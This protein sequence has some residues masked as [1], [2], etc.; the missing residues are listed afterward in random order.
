MMHL[1]KYIPSTVLQVQGE[2]H[3]HGCQLVVRRKFD[4]EIGYVGS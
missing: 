2:L 1:L 3:I 4:T